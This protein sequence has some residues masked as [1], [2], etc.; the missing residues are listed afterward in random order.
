MGIGFQVGQILRFYLT[1]CDMACM[2]KSRQYLLHMITYITKIVS[3][4]Y[5]VNLIHPACV[6]HVMKINMV[7][8]KPGTC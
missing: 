6:G 4:L 7:T 5:S 8:I 1:V 3:L 2:L